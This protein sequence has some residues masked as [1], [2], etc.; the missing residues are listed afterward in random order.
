MTRA[1]CAEPKAPPSVAPPPDRRDVDDDF[2]LDVTWTELPRGASFEGTIIALTLAKVAGGG[3]LI[4]IASGIVA[5]TTARRN[6][7]HLVGTALTAVAAY[8][9]PF[10]RAGECSTGGDAIATVVAI[11][12]YSLAMFMCAKSSRSLALTP[13]GMVTRNIIP[14]CFFM[15]A[16]TCARLGTI[17]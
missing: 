6:S 9:S 7:D 11:V 2:I 16:R 14:G 15:M 13:K 1:W 5:I 12:F 3:V 17:A 8:G 10:E 4:G